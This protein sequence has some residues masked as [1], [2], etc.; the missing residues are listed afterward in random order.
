MGNLEFSGPATPL[1]PSDIATVAA[2]L[3]C[4]S[5]AIKA[6][7]SVEAGGKGFLADTRPK[8]LFEAQQFS[9]LT[10]GIYDTSHPD[11]SSAT[12]NRSLY[13][14]STGEYDRLHSAIALN[15]AAALQA[16]SWG[17]FQIL[18]LNFK[19]CGFKDVETYVA[20]MC[21]TEGDHL[22][23]F[24]AFVKAS[25]LDDELRDR[26]W[27]DFA[28]RYNGPSYAQNKYDTK[29]AAAYDKAKA[30]EAVTA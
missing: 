9:K 6:V 23:A 3:G 13:K 25:K 4:E 19:L 14:N 26:R 30:E 5:A 8:I 17:L 20:A 11:I 15:R 29:L 1:Q 18:G 12:W 10:N 2:N 7:V 28:K 22:K 16:A 21:Q 27:A 24:A